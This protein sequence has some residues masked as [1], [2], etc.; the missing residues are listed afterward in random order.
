MGKRRLQRLIRV[1]TC[2][3]VKLLAIS[4]R[5]SFV[6]LDLCLVLYS[7]SFLSISTECFLVNDH[8][9]QAL[10]DQLWKKSK[11]GFNLANYNMN[12]SLSV[13]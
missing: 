4:C 6:Y 11:T 7:A 10:E 5:G 9:N 2:Q 12:H 13:S 1:Y 8:L 3:N